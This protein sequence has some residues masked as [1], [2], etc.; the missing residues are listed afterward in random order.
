MPPDG[1]HKYVYSGAPPE[2]VKLAAPVELPKQRTFVPEMFNVGFGLTVT[3]VAVLDGEAQTEPPEV[4]IKAV[5][6]YEADV[7]TVLEAPNPSPL[8]Q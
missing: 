3:T 6:V 4:I 2:A 7:E 1:D 8:F 5:A